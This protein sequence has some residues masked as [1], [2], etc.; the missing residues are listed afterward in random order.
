MLTFLVEL[1]VAKWLL[2]FSGTALK[3][4][5]AANIVTLPVVWFVFPLVS[6]SFAVV[7]VASELFA[8]VFEAL[9]LFKFGAGEIGLKKAFV[10]SGVM[11]V[12]S[13]MVGI[14]FLLL[15]FFIG[16]GF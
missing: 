10:S 12:V 13:V 3:T 1:A 2:K 11:N 8:I 14:V 5:A 15:S 7:F 4:V 9:A 6:S 16:I